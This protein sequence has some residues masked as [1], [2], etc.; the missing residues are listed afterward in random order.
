MKTFMRKTLLPPSYER[1][2]Y[3]RIQNL[4]QGSKSLKEYRKEMI[5]T[6]RRAN[7]QS[8]KLP[9]QGSYVGLIETFNAL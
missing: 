7:V 8:L 6:M 4:T 1:D 2:A 5:M 3:N 9:W